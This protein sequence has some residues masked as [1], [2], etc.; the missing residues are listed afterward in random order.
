VPS[1]WRAAIPHRIEIID[2][3]TSWARSDGTLRIASRH[4]TGDWDVLRFVMAHEFGHL[5][6]FAHGTKAY[7]G[8]PPAGFPYSGPRPEEMWADCVAAV[9]TGLAWGSHGL[10]G[11]SG[12]PLDWTR[13]WLAG[14]PPR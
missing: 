11:C 2:G 4:A 8:A 12:A 5:V 9:W 10:P 13:S 7:V 6:A 14:G 3:D 1:G